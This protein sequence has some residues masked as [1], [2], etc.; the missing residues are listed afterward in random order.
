MSVITLKV[1]DRLIKDGSGLPPIKLNEVID[2]SM[3]EAATRYLDKLSPSK[4]IITRLYENPHKGKL[5]IA[6]WGAKR[7]SPVYVPHGAASFTV[8]RGKHNCGVYTTNSHQKAIDYF[9]YQSRIG[10]TPIQFEEATGRLQIFYRFLPAPRG[11][12][13]LTLELSDDPDTLLACGPV[14]RLFFDC[15][16]ETAGRFTAIDPIK[17]TLSGDRRT[18]FSTIR[19]YNAAALPGVLPLVWESAT[20][21]ELTSIL[22]DLLPEVV[23]GLKFKVVEVSELLS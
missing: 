23:P 5:F 17:L 21:P 2:V 10:S 14:K 12:W 16:I 11:S 6:Y 4:K 9:C 22:V 15:M 13:V 18:L 19:I 7:K 1:L 3:R 8:I 20:E